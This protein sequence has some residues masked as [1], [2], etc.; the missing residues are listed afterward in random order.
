MKLFRGVKLIRETV[1][2]SSVCTNLTKVTK[3]LF[4][5]APSLH[6]QV[7]AAPQANAASGY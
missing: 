3:P 1:P 4:E 5:Y 2:E 7:F 6:V